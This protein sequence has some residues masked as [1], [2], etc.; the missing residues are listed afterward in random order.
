MVTRGSAISPFDPIS[1]RSSASMARFAFRSVVPLTRT[2]FVSSIFLSVVFEE[3]GKRCWRTSRS[4]T[5]LVRGPHRGVPVA[6]GV[7]SQVDLPWLAADRA[8]LHVRLPAPT[9]ILD[10]QIDPLAAIRAHH[11]D[12]VAHHPPPPPPPELPPPPPPPLPPELGL[13]TP[14]AIPAA[15]T[16]QAPLAPAPPNAPPPPVHPLPLDELEPDVE[17]DAPND[18]AA[19]DGP[20]KERNQRSTFAPNPNASR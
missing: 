2:R 7:A 1:T 17:C 11:R 10:V 16:P 12:E 19:L 20:P 13:A 6:V 14:A 15:A 8:V 3:S 9:V 5:L 18:V 4:C